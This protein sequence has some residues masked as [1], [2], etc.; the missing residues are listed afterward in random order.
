MQTT[1]TI[2]DR[3][4]GPPQRVALRS[5]RIGS[6][7]AVGRQLGKSRSSVMHGDRGAQT[8]TAA[9]ARER[10]PG[11]PPPRHLDET[12]D[13]VASYRRVCREAEA[14]RLFLVTLARRHGPVD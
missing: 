9:V 10:R 6:L 11:D 3:V 13:A 8:L 1:G 7:T 14:A 5:A 2:A 12:A 4:C